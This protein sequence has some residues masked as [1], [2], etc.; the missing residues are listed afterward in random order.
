MSKAHRMHTLALAMVCGAIGILTPVAAAQNGASTAQLHDLITQLQINPADPVL[1]QKVIGLAV[2]LRPV[3]EIPEEA[4]RHFVKAAVA[5]KDAQTPS[6][7]ERA[8]S[9]YTEA[10]KIA[11]WWPEAYYN[12]SKALEASKQYDAAIAQLRF[13]LLAAPD[14]KDARAVQD[15]IYALEERKEENAP[16]EELARF[17]KSIEGAVYTFQIKVNAAGHPRTEAR[18]INGQLH[19]FTTDDYNPGWR[20][21]VASLPITGLTFA[22]PPEP[23]YQCPSSRRP[24]GKVYTF[25]P[26]GSRFTLTYTEVCPE[27]GIVPGFSN[28]FTRN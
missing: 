15:H 28:L 7:Y 9:E 22:A 23:N 13:Y 14:A 4:R 11:P 24:I 12:L 6:A 2:S 8:V 19:L 27:L 10:L 26:D 16:A 20:E 21:Y 5:F 1:R 17:L 18:V 3:P 25:A